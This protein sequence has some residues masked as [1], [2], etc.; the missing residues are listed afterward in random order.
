MKIEKWQVM[1]AFAN[2]AAIESSSNGNFW[3]TCVHEPNWNWSNVDYRIANTTKDGYR[4]DELAEMEWVIFEVKGYAVFNGHVEKLVYD[5]CIDPSLI[6]NITV[7][8]KEK[9]LRPWT[10][11]EFEK[12]RDEWF[13]LKAT[14]WQKRK[15]IN[16]SIRHLIV[17]VVTFTFTEFSERFTRENG[18]PCGVLE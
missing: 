12:H 7:R 5:C 8:K 14:C 4:L 13:V 6:A 18:E 9:K 17:G 1:K 15:V 2:G 11:E 10:M 16:Y 3:G